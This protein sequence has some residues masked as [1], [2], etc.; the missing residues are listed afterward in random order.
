MRNQFAGVGQ[1]VR[2]AILERDDAPSIQ[3]H[4]VVSRSLGWLE[5][6]AHLM[7]AKVE[8]NG[9]MLL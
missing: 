1:P 8:K 7:L 6:L 5:M 4:Q 2:Q 9:Q 3:K